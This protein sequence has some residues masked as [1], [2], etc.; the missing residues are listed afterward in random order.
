MSN[1]TPPEHRPTGPVDS[2]H[3][4]I[5]ELSAYAAGD[6]AG[7]DAARVA[8]HLD[9][10]PECT[11][12]VAALQAAVADLQAVP[13]V[14]MPA[15]VAA[16]LDAAVRRE[17]AA[18]ARPAGSGSTTGSITRQQ[19]RST[20]WAGIAAGVAAVALGGAVVAGVL[21]GG[22]AD[23]DSAATSGAGRLE[24]AAAATSAPED[25]GAPAPAA[26]STAANTAAASA[27]PTAASGR[28]AIRA[29]GTDYHRD[30]PRFTTDVRA[31]LRTPP[32]AEIAAPSP[33]TSFS[34]E[35]REALGALR[36]G[37]DA[38]PPELLPFTQDPRRVAD[39]AAAL[40]GGDQ[41]TLVSVDLARF[42]GRPAAV[43]VFLG[44]EPATYGVYVVR[45]DC[46]TSETAPDPQLH[47]EVV[48][49]G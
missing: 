5:D 2:V 21:T 31:A 38:V 28:T 45:P 36:S 11:G 10:C 25:A 17:R 12:D 39:C 4:Q 13:A 18:A 48:T 43:F 47:Y 41:A 49:A 24:T 15:D 1:Q 8:G 26:G 3:P 35:E 27:A 7:A 9:G 46:A 42:T 14:T 29:T 23:E 37:G 40:T 30:T 6:L 19:R 20:A 22:G 16:R 32:A 33:E 34:A 44:S